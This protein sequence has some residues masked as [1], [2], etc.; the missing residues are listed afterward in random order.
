[1]S[2]FEMFVL[3][4]L[5]HTTTKVNAI[6]TAVNEGHP[7]R[8]EDVPEEIGS[9]C[10]ELMGILDQMSE[11]DA[12]KKFVDSLKAGIAGMQQAPAGH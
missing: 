6:L 9:A 8:K 7:V 4:A 5:I 11:T 2:D 1:M 10:S 12:S 3:L